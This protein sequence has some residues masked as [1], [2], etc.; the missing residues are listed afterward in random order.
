M[1]G[2]TSN[3]IVHEGRLDADAPLLQKP[4]RKEDQARKLR[5]VLDS[6]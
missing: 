3:A 6:A 4:F 5:A 2:Y 1:S